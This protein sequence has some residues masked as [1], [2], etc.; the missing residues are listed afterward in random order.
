[1]GRHGGGSRSGGGGGGSRSGGGSR[2]GGGSSSRSSSRPFQGSYN[3]SYYDRRGRYHSYYTTNRNFGT[4]SGSN[5][6]LIF[7]L[8]F[9]TFHMCVMLSGFVGSGIHFGGK[10]NGEISRIGIEDN[11]D[12]LSVE[13]E[14]AII[15][16]FQKVY[17][18]SGMPITL[19]TD[20]FSWMNHYNSLE[21][22]SEELYYSMG[23][24]EDAMVILFT[25]ED[26]DGFY[27]WE[28]DMY[29]GDD[30]EK[31]FSDDAFDTVLANF[32]KAMAQEDLVKAL[33]YAWN[34]VM[35]D[36]GKMSIDWTI[37]PIGLMILAFYSIFYIVIIGSLKKNKDANEY[38][39]NN[40]DKLSYTPMTLYSACPNCGAS[41]ITQ[42]TNC[43]YC[44]T[45]LKKSEGNINYV[46]PY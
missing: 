9:V 27:D 41:N 43:K 15:K 18:A 36:L 25:A 1:M 45:L 23:F 13:E 14:M 40:P 34:S 10:V 4:S 20:D 32:Q 7:A 6:G 38:F 19:Y 26:L 37:L 12:I 17:D 39:K 2:G 29:C 28:Y 42:D 21:V 5:I 46:D 24:E 35:D 11:A 22:Y 33:D 8:V 3:R 30:T 16:T 31:C 44:G